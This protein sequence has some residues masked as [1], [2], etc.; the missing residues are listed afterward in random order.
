M[1][2]ISNFFVDRVYVRL[3]FTHTSQSIN[4]CEKK[5]HLENLSQSN[6]VLF[7][8]TGASWKHGNI[9]NPC[10]TPFRA[11]IRVTRGRS[12]KNKCLLPKDKSVLK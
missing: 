3:I 11:Q 2:L 12:F 1:T 6:F 10:S 9:L 7:L 8:Y 5:E 4:I